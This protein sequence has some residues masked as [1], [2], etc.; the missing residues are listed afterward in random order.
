LSPC[1]K[2]VALLHLQTFERGDQLVGVLAAADFE[3]T[4]P[5][6]SAFMAS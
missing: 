3:F 4:M 2:S 1:G 5:I 6:L